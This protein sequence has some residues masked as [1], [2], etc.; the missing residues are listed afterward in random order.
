[1]VLTSVLCQA[2]LLALMAV[3]LPLD[4][5]QIAGTI[6][7]RPVDPVN[8]DGR[9]SASKYI[10]ENLVYTVNISDVVNVIFRAQISFY[11]YFYIYIMPLQHTLCLI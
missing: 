7:W 1:M 8:F 9:V 6:Q 11:C 3:I 5:R 10:W 2:P 4:A